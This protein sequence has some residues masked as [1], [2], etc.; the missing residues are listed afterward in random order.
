MIPFYK[1]KFAPYRLVLK[2]SKNTR[3][4]YLCTVGILRIKIRYADIFC[5]KNIIVAE[6]K[7]KECKYNNDKTEGRTV[8]DWKGKIFQS[9]HAT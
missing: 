8:H 6:E 3:L 7:M 9:E 1:Y 5:S 4:Q 2:L